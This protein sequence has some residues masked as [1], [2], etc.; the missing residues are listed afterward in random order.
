LTPDELLSLADRCV[1]CGACLPH[2]PTFGK[3]AN[4]A[5]SPRGRIAL[6]Q[7]WATG[8][9]ELTPRL[10]EHLDGCLLC[11]ACEHA[12]PSG[13]EFGQLADG[14]K[15][16]RMAK[17]PGW[18]RGL[19]R[20]ALGWL[21]KAGRGRT[22]AL[23]SGVYRRVGFA[24][25]AECVGLTRHPLLRTLHRLTSAILETAAPTA[26]TL[27]RDGQ[28]FDFELFVG[29]MGGLT[30]GHAVAALRT[31]CER[32][33]LSMSIPES[34]GCCG[35][36]S[37]HAGFPADADAMRRAQTRAPGAPP[38]AGL[39]SACVAELRAAPESADTW[40]LCD[41]LDARASLER[42]RFQ[43]LNLRV[44]VHEPCTHRNLL[45][46]NGAVHRLLERIPGLEILP[47]PDT[48]CCGAA[49]LYMLEQTELADALLDDKV[50]AISALALDA[51]V[52]TNGGCAL[53]LLGG[54]RAARSSALVCHPVELLV[55]S[56]GDE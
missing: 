55:R 47:L 49:G 9:L 39:A 32:M 19:K 38:L 43:T 34:F 30:Q 29:C 22:L 16:A 31:L 48:R 14:A 11:R 2:C 54:L 28:R 46:G 4:E 23:A 36:L 20:R 40:E 45:G 10:A 27:A 18:R 12:C 17:L 33:D 56:L 37:R 7:G 13:V 15:A 6:V 21:A 50:A 3:L 41:F 42:L 53:H 35:A 8:Q 5:D 1:K 52:T 51:V 26:P 24:A 25:L 44:A